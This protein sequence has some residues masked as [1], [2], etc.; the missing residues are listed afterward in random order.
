V[1]TEIPVSDDRMA[2]ANL[3]PTEK[4]TFKRVLGGLTLLDTLQGTVGMPKILDHV[5]SL[6]EKSVLAFMGMMENIHAKSYSTIFTTLASTQEIDEVFDWVKGNKYLQK[7]AKLVHAYYTSIGHKYDLYMAMVASTF[8][9]SFLFYSGFFYPLYLAGQGKMTASGEI[10]NLII[11]D[12]AIHGVFVG[13]LAQILKSTLSKRDQELVEEELYE[14][15]DKLYRNEVAYTDELYSPIGLAEEVKTFVRYNCNKSLANLGYD[16]HFPE[17][18]INPIVLNGLRTD[19]KQH[20]F[21][22]VG[23]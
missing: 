6:Q 19:T 13:Q 23:L 8:L 10:I 21:F 9:E 16:A 2:W 4:E 1:D 5:E 20:D 22:S 11:R 15:L 7:K 18:N 17:E 12:E 14:L 3:S